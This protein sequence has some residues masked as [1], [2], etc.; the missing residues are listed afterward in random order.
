LPDAVLHRNGGL[1]AGHLIPVIV[2]RHGERLDEVDGQE[3]R[4]VR[5]QETKHDPP[6]TEAGW[7]Q[8]RQAARKLAAV[9]DNSDTRVSIYSSPTVRTLSTAAAIAARLRNAVKQVTPAYSLNCCAAAQSHG[10][11]KAFP[12][13][14]PCAETLSG[15][16]LACWPPRG[17]PDQVDHRQRRG[18]AL[19]EAVK[20]L[21]ALHG[22]GEGLVVVTHREG[23]WELLQHI[24]GKMKGGY[25]NITWLTFDAKTLALAAW[26]PATQ[27]LPE[28]RPCAALER[29]G[30]LSSATTRLPPTT[31][32]ADTDALATV[33][34]H[35]NGQ[36]IIHRDGRGDGTGTLLWRTPGVRGVWADGGAVADGESV[37]LLSSPMASEGNEGDFVLV[38]RSSGVQ[39]WTKVRNIRLV[40]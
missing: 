22:D 33:L 24:G 40:G 1:P 39:G 38:Q 3:W 9:L 16:T 14:E 31:E 6:L 11:A 5:T 27:P 2:V 18:A 32:V 12:T 7:E 13:R 36:V 23:I 35:G 30:L 8:S 19:V 10:V 25:C 20:E 17:N 21:A 4:R 28:T 15:V 26:D 34:A 37:T 29:P